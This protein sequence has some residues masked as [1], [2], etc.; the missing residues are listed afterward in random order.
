M[1]LRSENQ[2][3]I[4]MPVPDTVFGRATTKKLDTRYT[5]IKTKAK[6]KEIPFRW[7]NFTDFLESLSR[8]ADEEYHPDTHRMEFDFHQMSASGEVYGYCEETMR[9]TEIGKVKVNGS[10]GARESRPAKPAPMLETDQIALVA[11]LTRLVLGGF[12]GS[13]DELVEQAVSAA[14]LSSDG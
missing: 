10:K 6:Q 2:T 13:L 7:D 9:L 12:E 14:G 11:E 4:R 8:V 3:P 5:A 1:L